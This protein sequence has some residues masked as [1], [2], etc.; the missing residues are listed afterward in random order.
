[1]R[2]T[3]FIMKLAPVG[4]FGLTARM[5]ARTGFEAAGPLLMFSATVLAGLAVFMFLILPLL[6]RLAG[7]VNPWPMFPAMAPAL[8]TA[9]STSSSSAALA[10]S[11]DCMERRV[12]V[13][14]RVCG[15]VL[16]LGASL[17]QAG[18][19]LYECAAVLFIAQAY[20]LEL[21]LGTQFTIVALALITS[22]GIAGIPAASLVAIT[23]IL[24]AVGLPAEAIGV[25]LVFDRVLDM[26]RSAVNLF[27]DAC[28]A[29]I[30]ARMEGE[31]GIPKAR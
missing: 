13:S 15:F 25:L 2:M 21:T 20:G 1:M 16:P 23:V 24:T 18:S 7:R 19:A 5:V 4:V 8:L 12:G 26:A 10:T 22:M 3:E 17:N 6:I 31:T 27:V 28:C 29:L 9:F 30:V 11:I 14:N